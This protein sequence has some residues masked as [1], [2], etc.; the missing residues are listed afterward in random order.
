MS[1]NPMAKTPPR[2]YSCLPRA[3]GLFYAGDW[4]EPL[5][6]TYRETLNPAT[7]LP[8][9]SVAHANADD[10]EAAIALAH[11]AWLDWSRTSPAK[12]QGMLHEAARRLRE[13]AKEFAMIDAINTG[14]PVAEMVGDA[15]VAADS[16]DFFAGLIPMLKGE[17]IP[18]DGNSL[19]YSVREPLGVV[20]RIVAYNHPLMFAAGKI[21]APL[22]AGNAVIVKPPEQAPLSCLRLAEV[23]KDVFPPGVLNILPGGRECGQTLASHPLV[24][25]VTLI[26]SV[27]TGRA[28]LR[29]A[30]DTI[31]PALLELGGKNALIA[32]P[33][34]D[35]EA[36]VPGIAR[37]MNFTWAGQSCGSTSRV[38]LHD[39]IHDTVLESVSIYV[40][41]MYVPGVP[42]DATTTM[43]PLISAQ[44]RDEVMDFI[45]SA[46]REG[47]RL[48][49]GGKAPDVPELSGGYYI[50]PTIFADVSASMRIAREEIFGP[51]MSVF[52]WKDEEDLFRIVNGT[53]FGLTA[54]IW[55]RALSTA[56]RAANRVEAGYVW[57]NQTS[58]HYLGVPFGGVKHSGLGREECLEELLD[59]TATKSI[60]IQL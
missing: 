42:T 1:E 34:A 41:Q 49:T 20:A 10:A 29:G 16:L 31:K 13:H 14:N 35:I 5:S 4:H 40:Q 21:A 32:F 46:N 54:S 17:T 26:G 57:I 7:G 30:A 59:F 38:F 19:H 60:N 45:A 24:K 58:R 43:G 39:S 12:R 25:K 8:V 56:H 3:R 55:T 48:V 33:D 51:V 22:A 23:L 18:V 47:A 11:E 52:R 2:E 15:M 27:N 44:R 36:L 6:A 9:A 50:E 37:G 28:I 53:E